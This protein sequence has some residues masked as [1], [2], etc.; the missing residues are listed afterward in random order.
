MTV[1]PFRVAG[2][3]PVKQFVVAGPKPAKS[4]SYIEIAESSRAL[5]DTLLQH[6]FRAKQESHNAI[7]R[8]VIDG[9]SE[10]ATDPRVVGAIEHEERLLQSFVDL[11]FRAF[12]E[13]RNDRLAF[14]RAYW[15]Y[16]GQNDFARAA[17]IGNSLFR[18]IG[19]KTIFA[20]EA[21]TGTLAARWGGHGLTPS[22]LL[23]ENLRQYRAA[24]EEK[25]SGIGALFLN[26]ASKARRGA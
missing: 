5:A 15:E 18:A 24:E 10:W 13:T 11:P 23:E 21:K 8:A 4:V 7:E 1:Q 20:F 16:D 6:L 2:P 26:F 19:S 12:P 17:E 25:R 22:E 9:I 14:A 3:K